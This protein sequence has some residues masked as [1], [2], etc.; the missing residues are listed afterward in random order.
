MVQN[1]AERHVYHTN[2]CTSVHY[3]DLI[4]FLTRLQHSTEW[5]HLYYFHFRP[6][7]V[8]CLSSFSVD[9]I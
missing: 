1:F 6:L 9:Y 8:A 5:L 7:F 4:F 3:C 2:V